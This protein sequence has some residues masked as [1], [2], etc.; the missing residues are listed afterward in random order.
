MTK[1]R[2]R[3]LIVDDN[4][5]HLYITKKNLERESSTFSIKIVRSGEECLEALGDGEF[6]CIISDYDMRP[7]M[8]GI[9]LLQTLRDR[10]ID[11]PVIVVSEVGD[12]RIEARALNS[13]AVDYF[14]K[15]IGFANFAT[16]VSSIN[17]AIEK[18]RKTGEKESATEPSYA[19]V[20]ADE[21]I[22]HHFTN[23]SD[24]G[25]VIESEGQTIAQ[26]NPVAAEILG[27]SENALV[28]AP[29]ASLV[30]PEDRTELRRLILQAL[31][32]LRAT[33]VVRFA[34]GNSNHRPFRVVCEAKKICGKVVGA[35]IS[36][37]EIKRS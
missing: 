4:D 33:S 17:H 30:A 37:R 1:N 29:V 35:Y 9:D 22:P 24:V 5:D 21:P 19:Q 26:A 11:I 23:S 16:V 7:G 36:A 15:S 25:I 14:N 28:G 31:W 3:I 20:L 2:K 6:D 18:H 32:G 27:S 8:N 34:C 10:N 12:E 13:G